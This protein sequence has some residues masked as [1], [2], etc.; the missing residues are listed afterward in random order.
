MARFPTSEAKGVS[1]HAI[2]FT[3]NLHIID[4]EPPVNGNI[5]TDIQLYAWNAA[6]NL[7]SGIGFL[8]P[9]SV[10]ALK[11]KITALLLKDLR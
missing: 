6:L 3:M 2:D 5:L 1:E 4:E 8:F 10:S 11:M 9:F 7:A